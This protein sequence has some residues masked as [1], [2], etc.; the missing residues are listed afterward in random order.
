MGFIDDITSQS[1][2]L[3]RYTIDEVTIIDKV[4]EELSGIGRANG[5]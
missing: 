1:S 4:L 3:G 5:N 2:H